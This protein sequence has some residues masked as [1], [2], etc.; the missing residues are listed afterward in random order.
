MKRLG[1]ALLI[2]TALVSGCTQQQQQPAPAPSISP[3]PSTVDAV[4]AADGTDAKACE[5]GRCQIL[6]AQQSDFALDGKF[7]CDGILITFT[8]PKEVEFDVSV[9]DGDDL[10]ATVKGTGKLALA[11]G[12]TLTVEQT[13]PA[14]AVLRVAPA[15]NDPDNHTGTG[16]EGFSLWSG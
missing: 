4:A 2:T 11:Y 6:V 8:A 1:P 10:H 14:G 7:N 13:G 5:D 12:L 16:T 9:Q 15:K 3:S